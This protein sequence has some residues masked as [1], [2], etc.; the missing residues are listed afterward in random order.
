M[1]KPRIAN[2]TLN[3]A[4]VVLLAITTHAA[5]A[6]GRDELSGKK[7]VAVAND[8]VDNA[9]ADEVVRPVPSTVVIELTGA[10]GHSMGQTRLK[11][12]RAKESFDA[13]YLKRLLDVARSQGAERVILHI[14]SHGGYAFERNRI[15]EVIDEYRDELEFIAYVDEA[16]G[17]AVAIALSCEQIFINES[18]YFGGS[19]AKDPREGYGSDPQWLTWE[20]ENL[21]RIIESAGRDGKIADALVRKEL[22]LWWHEDYGFS[23]PTRTTRTTSNE[24][25]TSATKGAGVTSGHSIITDRQGNRIAEINSQGAIVWE[26]RTDSKSRS[27]GEKA[28]NGGS[29]NETSWQGLVGE[30]SVL[31][32]NNTELLMTGIAVGEATNIDDCLTKLGIEEPIDIARQQTKARKDRRRNVTAA[33]K[34]Y[35]LFDLL[36]GATVKSPMRS[37]ARNY[38]S[39]GTRIMGSRYQRAQLAPLQTKA[40]HRQ[41]KGPG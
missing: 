37:C 33:V 5:V 40:L 41:P 25:T 1:S 22:Q 4:I 23:I 2:Q 13:P 10:V 36:P 30:F 35:Q 14:D 3:S 31:S 32:L 34:D 16:R 27:S 17:A 19:L 26:A 28:E 18:C 12:G 8:E 21:R 20:V 6:F 39:G 24:S 11:R 7:E 29:F 9:K 15:C 38:N